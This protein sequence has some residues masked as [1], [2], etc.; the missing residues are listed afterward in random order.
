MR[1]RQQDRNMRRLYAGFA[2]AAQAIGPLHMLQASFNVERDGASLNVE[3][4]SGPFKRTRTSADIEREAVGLPLLGGT[5][6]LG[7]S[8]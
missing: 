4:I 8:E 7:G 2:H 1:T 6:W 5:A 3:K